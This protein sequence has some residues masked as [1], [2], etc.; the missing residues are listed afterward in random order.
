VKDRNHNLNKD[1]ANTLLS[2][3]RDCAYAP[4]PK[5]QESLAQDHYYNIALSKLKKQVSQ[6]LSTKWLGISQV[7]V[8]SCY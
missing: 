3:L 1:Q 5:P 7:S 2:L 8:I 4:S 6:W